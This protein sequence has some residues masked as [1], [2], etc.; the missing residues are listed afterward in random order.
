M[1]NPF[2]KRKILKNGTPGRAR[3]ISMSVPDS[4]ASSQNIAMTLQVFVEGMAPYEVEDQ[5]MVSRKDPIGMGIELPVK[6]DAANPQKVAIDWDAAR[7]ESAAET[8]ARREALAAQGPVGGAGTPAVGGI[9]GLGSVMESARQM[10]QQAMQMGAGAMPV[11]DTR[12]DPELRAKIEQV[13]G[14]PLETGKAETLDFSKDPQ[15]AAQVM[16]VVQQHQLE[17]MG[18]TG[19]GAG[20]GQ[21]AAPQPGSDDALSKLERLAKLHEAGALTDTEFATEKKQLLGEI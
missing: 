15:K 20:A 14:H 13:L 2:T 12:N 6:V 16:Q 4:S 19:A 8:T 17:K 7:E 1:L 9:A 21:A 5:W 11:V 18:M 3:V 10:Q